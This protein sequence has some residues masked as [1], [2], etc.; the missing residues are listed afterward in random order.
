MMDAPMPS[1]LGHLLA[2][3]SVAIAASPEVRLK[4]DP[5]TLKA[6]VARWLMPAALL[7]AFV[8]AAPDL[9]LF[10]SGWHRTATHSLTMTALLMILTAVVTGQVT[11][12]INWRMVAIVG[13]AHLSH[14]L[15]DWL[16]TD[17]T[18]P[19]G[20]QL[21]WPFSPR[22][23]IAPWTIFPRTERRWSDPTFFP[24]NAWAAIVELGVMLPIA[25]LAW[26]WSVRR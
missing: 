19:E 12:R 7:G 15:L 18:P 24:A 9:D 22:Y 8:G 4:P 11:G 17:P 6:T 3:W 16:G 5:A 10:L 25:V 13:G 21:L 20:F 1:P 23:F 2:G 26:K 14:L